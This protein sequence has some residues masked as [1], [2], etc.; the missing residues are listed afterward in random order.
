VI[1]TDAAQAQRG[2]M[3]ASG[4]GDDNDDPGSVEDCACPRGVLSAQADV[5]TAGKM[6][7]G[8]LEGIA[9]VENLSPGISQPQDFVQINGAKDLLEILIE[10]SALASVENSVEAEIRGSVPGP[11]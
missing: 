8:V 7:L 3:L 1:E 5:D 11:P 2:L 9:D 4:L 6:V 10:L